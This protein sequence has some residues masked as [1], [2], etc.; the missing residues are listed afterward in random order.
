MCVS[1]RKLN[2]IAQT[3]QFPIPC[4]D[5]TISTVG[6]GSNKIWI[7]SLDAR[8]VYHQI[9]VCHGDREKIAFFAPDN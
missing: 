5:D 9:S 1:Y 4:C 2:G 3:F 6:A 7:I 8:Q